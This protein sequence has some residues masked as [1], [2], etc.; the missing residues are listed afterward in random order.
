MTGVYPYHVGLQHNVI[1]G[2]QPNFLPSK[3]TLLPQ[4]LK[5]RGYT[6]HMVGKWHLGFCNWSYT[7][8]YRGFDSFLGYYQGAEDYYT[9]KIALGYDFRFNKEVYKNTKG[10]Y[11]TNTFER[12]AV[13]IISSHNASQSP[14]FLY[15][16]FQAVHSPV[17]VPKHYEDMYPNVVN[18]ERRKYCGMVTAL[19][20]AVGRIMKALDTEG[21]LDNAVVIFTTDNGGLP[22]EG[23]N[24]YPLRGQKATLWEGGTRGPAFVYSKTLLKKTGYVNNGLMHIVDWNPTIQAIAGSPPEDGQDGVNQWDMIS[25][26]TESARKEFV[27]NFDN[28]AN[29]GA[30]RVGDYK[31]IMGNAGR[32]G[33][34]PPPT[35]SDWK[36]MDNPDFRSWEELTEVFAD[37]IMARINISSTQYQLFNVKEDPTEHVDLAPTE[38]AILKRMIVKMKDLQKSQVPA[39]F[40]PP[41]PKGN[42]LFH[43]GIWTP[44]WC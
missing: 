28:I 27:Y 7:P 16:P 29:N 12:R 4:R 11:S 37:E 1:M 35:V 10:E 18:K 41:D 38:T 25:E 43:G 39:V 9:H 2:S 42:P 32:G 20:D 36:W 33:W 19:D 30:I 15:L 22:M 13:E 17:E 24:N 6:S 23:G 3:Y 5:K 26:G 14:L 40:P 21:F 8:T 31:L 44:G 34:Y